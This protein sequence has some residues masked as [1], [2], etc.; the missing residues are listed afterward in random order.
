MEI[1]VMDIDSRM[2]RIMFECTG[3]NVAQLSA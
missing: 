3:F 1:P 2:I